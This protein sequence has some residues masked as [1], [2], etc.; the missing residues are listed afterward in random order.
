MYTQLRAIVRTACEVP[1]Q[2]KIM[3]PMVSSLEEMRHVRAALDEVLATFEANGKRP[4]NKIALGAMIEVPS[5]AIALDGMVAEMDFISIGSNDL[6]QYLVAADRVNPEVAHLY[7]PCHPAV[8]RTLHQIIQT[9]HLRRKSVSVCGEIACDEN[10]IP[11]LLGL[12][13]DVLSVPPR[14]FLR[15]KNRIR[16]LNFETCADMAQ[17]ALLAGNSEDIRKLIQQNQDEDS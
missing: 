16:N 2:I 14:M 11:M 13:T 7:D 1:A 6:I 4:L 10:M 3:V 15:V 17:A 5:A 9:A 12:G 8:V